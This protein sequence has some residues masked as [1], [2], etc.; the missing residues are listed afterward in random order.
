MFKERNL[1]K[2]DLINIGK[3]LNLSNINEITEYDLINQ[4]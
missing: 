2:N 1:T 4:I 3:I